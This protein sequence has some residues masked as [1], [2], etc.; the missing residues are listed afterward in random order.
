MAVAPSPNTP[1]LSVL[2]IEINGYS[3]IVLTLP[4][5]LNYIICIYYIDCRHN[6]REECFDGNSLS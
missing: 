5:D 6:G 1:P 2:Q 4:M 3:P